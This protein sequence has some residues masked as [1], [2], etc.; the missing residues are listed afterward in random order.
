MNTV[1]V[2]VPVAPSEDLL[3]NFLRELDSLP[4]EFEILLVSTETE[5]R[6]SSAR[7][8][9][10]T[11]ARAGRAA[12]LNEGA[13]QAQSEWLWFV[14]ADS[15]NLEQLVEPLQAAQQA[16]PAALLYFDL[17]Y[18]DGTAAHRISAWGARWRSR[19]FGAPFGDQAFCVTRALHQQLGGYREDVRYGEDH[20]YARAARAAKVVLQPVAARIGTSARMHLQHGWLRIV[21]KY[22]W[23]WISQALADRRA[24]S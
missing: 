15:R 13:C 7:W 20:L 14:H 12:A 22:Q 2:I 5:R 18:Y 8:Q 24:S 3:D 10:V 11:A 1:S 16:H 6:P 19:L 9:W 23:M 17:H 21:L 4:P